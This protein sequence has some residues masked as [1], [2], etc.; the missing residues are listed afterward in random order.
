MVFN[1]QRFCLHDGNGIRT[2]VFYKGCTLRCRW[3]SNPESLDYSY[4]L[5]F[6]SR[7]CKGFG[8]CVL[9]DPIVFSRNGDRLTIN[10]NFINSADILPVIVSF[11]SATNISASYFCFKSL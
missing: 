6:D 8:D 4:S 1:I 9:A 2:L 7:L 10:R 11:L 3:C 5:M